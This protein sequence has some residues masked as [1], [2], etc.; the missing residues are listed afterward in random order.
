MIRIFLMSLLL[1]GCITTS[2]G[3]VGAKYSSMNWGYY[4]DMS[5]VV[6]HCYPNEYRII[7]RNYR[8]I[9]GAGY[10]QTIYTCSLS[11]GL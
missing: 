1:T 8:N 3:A 4:T 2:T 7:A 10:I 6:A 5:S 9:F 11:K